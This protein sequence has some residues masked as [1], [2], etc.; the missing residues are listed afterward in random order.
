MMVTAAVDEELFSDTEKGL[1]TTAVGMLLLVVEL[2]ATRGN[3]CGCCSICCCVAETTL[4]GD[5]CAGANL[6]GHGCKTTAGG[7][8]CCGGALLGLTYLRYFRL[9]LSGLRLSPSPP[10]A[11]AANARRLF[12]PPSPSSRRRRRLTRRT[13][14]PTS[15]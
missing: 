4:K 2:A 11:A 8:C 9:L 15:C 14:T 12:L 1:A 6:F 5:I 13:P 7:R 10:S 3:E